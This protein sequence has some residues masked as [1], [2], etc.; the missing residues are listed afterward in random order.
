M[1]VSR[2]R[3]LPSV[4]SSGDESVS[5]DS[6]YV[7]T[8]DEVTSESYEISDNKESKSSDASEEEDNTRKKRIGK[9]QSTVRKSSPKREIQ[10]TPRHKTRNGCKTVT[11][12]DCVS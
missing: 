2:K 6:E 3:F 1:S 8:N 11:Y 7:P 10:N 5:E 12:K 9:K 4:N